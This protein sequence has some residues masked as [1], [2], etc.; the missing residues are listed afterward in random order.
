[1]ASPARRRSQAYQVQQYILAPPGAGSATP[2][3]VGNWQHQPHLMQWE[4]SRHQT[5][6]SVDTSTTYA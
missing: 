3:G 1:M 4:Q 2:L 6:G 5:G